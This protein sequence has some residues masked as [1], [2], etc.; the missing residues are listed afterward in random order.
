M[1]E[2]ECGVCCENYSII[3]QISPVCGHD[4]LCP[5]CIK[6]HIE[7]ELNTK[8][9]TVQVRCPKSRCTTELTYNDVKRLASKELFDR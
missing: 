9:D 6:R 7:A 4:D 8:G 1:T 3:Q 5:I 2:L